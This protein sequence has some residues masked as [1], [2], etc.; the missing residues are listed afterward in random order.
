M[1]DVS[2]RDLRNHGGEVVERAQRGERLTI[3]RAGKPVAEL[4]GLRRPT[5]PL[6]ELM[7]RWARLP[8]IDPSELRRDV[9]TVT[10]ASV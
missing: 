1:A 2:I 9:D 4:V 3:T 8:Q 5:L 10:D 6:E 7:A